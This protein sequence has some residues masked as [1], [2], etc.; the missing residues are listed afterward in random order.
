MS[1]CL[2]KGLKSYQGYSRPIVIAYRVRELLVLRL[3]ATRLLVAIRP[4]PCSGVQT[5]CS[6]HLDSG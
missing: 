1:A 5:R 2:G 6:F 4:E 3:I